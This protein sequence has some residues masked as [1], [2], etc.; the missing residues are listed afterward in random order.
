MQIGLWTHQIYT[1]F[2]TQKDKKRA[3]IPPTLHMEKSLWYQQ[4]KKYIQF[5]Q[6][7]MLNWKQKLC[8]YAEIDLYLWR[9][10]FSFFKPKKLSTD[11]SQTM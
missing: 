10:D 6:T 9:K 7:H 1:K 11:L 2:D 4:L 3:H 8:I 5:G